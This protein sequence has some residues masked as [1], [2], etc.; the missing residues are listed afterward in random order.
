MSFWPFVRDEQ[1]RARV[2]RP[3]DRA[4]LASLL[5]R[6]WRRHGSAA[7]ED[8]VELLQN[9]ISTI[10][11]SHDDAYGFLG[12]HLRAPAGDP[13]QTWVDLNLA[14]VG[15]SGRVDGALTQL[16]KAAMPA[17][18]RE[19]ATGIVCLAPPGWLQEGLARS[20]FAEE[21]QVITYAY[22]D[23]V[24]LLSA[25]QPA[26]LRGAT[27]GDANAVLEINAQAFGPF[28]QYDDSVVLGWMLTADRGVVAEI[29]GEIVGFA[30]TTTGLAEGYAHLIRIATHPRFQGRGIGRQLVVDSVRFARTAGAPG[31]ALNTQASNR[32]SRRLYEALGFRLSGHSLAV[33]VYRL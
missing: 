5:A 24:R 19:G 27:G 14:V 31:L 21:D 26:V 1:A 29:D 17:L 3:G 10:L 25:D 13:P 23:S 33:M 6:T 28:W 7:L 32:I 16:V 22:T 2:A 18:R 20:G 8:Q 9:G 30:I 12:L 4:A 15:S 11:L